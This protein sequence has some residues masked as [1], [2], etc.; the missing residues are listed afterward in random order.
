MLKFYL[1]V[2]SLFLFIGI[3]QARQNQLYVGETYT[4]DYRNNIA[5]GIKKAD[6][7]MLPFL[8]G[9]NIEL[10]DRQWKYRFRSSGFKAILKEQLESM[11]RYEFQY[12]FSGAEAALV[13]VNG[14]IEAY[15]KWLKIILNGNYEGDI[16]KSYFRRATFKY[17]TDGISIFVQNAETGILNQ[18]C[19]IKAEMEPKLILTHN[20][21]QKMGNVNLIWE[22]VADN[23]YS[24]RQEIVLVPYLGNPPLFN[25]ESKQKYDTAFEFKR[26]CSVLLEGDLPE[27]VMHF[28][29]RTS[30]KLS[31]RAIISINDYQQKQI[32]SKELQ[33]E[34]DPGE[35]IQQQVAIPNEQYGFFTIKLE[36]DGNL[37]G[38]HNYCVLPPPDRPHKAGSIFGGIIYPWN[39]KTVEKLDLMDWIGMSTVRRAYPIVAQG[40]KLPAKPESG[41]YSR[42]DA[43]EIL[44]EQAKR[45]IE[46]IALT[47]AIQEM[48]PGTFRLTEGSNEENIRRLP[49]DFAEQMKIEY[50]KAKLHDPAIMVGSTGLAGID[51]HWLEEMQESGVWD[52][53]DAIFV[54]LH[55]FPRAPEVNNTMTREFWLHDRVTLLRELMNKYGDKPVYDSENGYL[56]L[57]PDRRVENYPLRSI[58]ESNIAAAFMVRSYL[59]SLA[60][61]LKNKM[62]F[63]I[64]SY[65]GFG[66]TERNQPL[67]SYPAYAA[68]T[69]LLDGAEYVGELLS[70]G[71]VSSAMDQ[72]SEFSRSWFGQATP[73][74]EKELLSADRYTVQSDRNPDLKPYLYI[75]VF[76]S[77][78]NQPVIAVWATLKRQ[79][80]VKHPVDTLA[81][82][83]QKP[84][85]SLL[86]NGFPVKEE[87]ESV[88]VRFDT[89]VTEIEIA[90][91][92][93]NRKKV[94]TEDGFVTLKLDDYP[95]FI[96][97]ANP[98]LL[99]EAEKFNLKIFPE[100]LVSNDNW[101]TL[102]QLILPA[103]KKHPKRKSVFDKP[104]L[105]ATLEAG[106]PYPVYVRLSNFG[107]TSEAGTVSLKLPEGWHC[108]PETVNFDIAPSSEK[109]IVAEFKVTADRAVDKAKITSI[110]SS[111]K[112]GK[113]ADSTMNVGVK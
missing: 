107:N 81:W 8:S 52:Y 24:M 36:I 103:E 50:V 1:T 68:M 80:V 96:L 4:L 82:K 45:G 12:E 64:D 53:M 42:E 51:I 3:V 109:N 6:G 73:G 49:A 41:V 105:S 88:P 61:G 22:K 66:I 19:G 26:Y 79:D 104:N 28:Y 77:P 17:A 62:W 29:N 83:D 57:D 100:K 46:P 101:K 108:A 11:S 71:H 2:I 70:P 110:V 87:P 39:R 10:A 44:H 60:Y 90:D 72:N 63:S 85:I 30:E 91:I 15:P 86:W 74:L 92:M 55:C 56:T 89:G 59:Q 95:Q 33:L 47:S 75:R 9:V 106:K 37:I 99:K 113:I 54:H 76:R 65:G 21:S 78:D 48:P 20:A 93:G 84:G 38:S 32:A 35:I 112:L 67:P 13:S 5:V 69:L 27:T 14:I 94:K 23:R 18:P 31:S 102:I 25:Q 111:D 98:K 58:S 43:G 34:A 97:G 16:S 40:V 7:A